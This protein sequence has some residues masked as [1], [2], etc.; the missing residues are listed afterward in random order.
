MKSTAKSSLRSLPHQN[1][2][3][4]ICHSKP[5]VSLNHDLASQIHSSMMGMI[6]EFYT[7]NSRSWEFICFQ[8]IVSFLF[9]SR[10]EIPKQIFARVLWT[11]LGSFTSWLKILKEECRI[12][13]GD[14]EAWKSSLPRH[15]PH[16]QIAH[17]QISMYEAGWE[18][19]LPGSYGF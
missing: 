18:G 1:T 12:S 6:S 3:W 2:G 14:V 8:C 10:K 13:L 11:C 16:S 9:F 17:T 7:M 4:W 5:D 15:S 19:S